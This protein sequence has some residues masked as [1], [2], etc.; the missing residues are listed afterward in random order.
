[1][2]Q[3][4]ST[5]NAFVSLMDGRMYSKFEKYRVEPSTILTIAVILDPRHKIQFVDFCYSK[6]YDPGSVEAIR[7]REKL[8]SMFS[9]YMSNAPLKSNIECSSNSSPYD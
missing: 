7:V 3:Q 8:N 9:L 5:K 1:M 6:L 2:V 4:K